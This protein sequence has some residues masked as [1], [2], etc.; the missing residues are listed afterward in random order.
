MKKWLL[1]IFT[2]ICFF[3]VDNDVHAFVNKTNAEIECIYANGVVIGMSYDKTAG[4]NTAYVKEY[5]VTKTSIIDGNPVSN[6]SLYSVDA[7]VSSLNNLSCPATVSYWIGW[8]LHLNETYDAWGNVIDEDVSKSYRGVYSYS[9][10][11]KVTASLTKIETSGWWIFKSTSATA[12]VIPVTGTNIGATSP[13]ATIPL[14]GERI[15]LIDDIGSDGYGHTYKLYTEN[16]QAVGS[17]KYV[18]IYKGTNNY[19]QVGKVITKLQGA[20]ANAEYLCIEPSV[21]TQDSDRGETAYK[22]SSIRHKVH[23]S[24][25]KT[26]SSG[27]LY[28]RTTES[29]KTIIPENKESFC[30]RYS[31]TAFVLIDI[32]KIMQILVPAIVIIFTGIEIGRIVLAGN[33]EEELP[34]RKKSIFIRGRFYIGCKLSI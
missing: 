3:I 24:T 34:K 26:C 23:A 28:V 12:G 15:Y 13:Y 18:Q 6:V 5:P 8:E 17:S 10:H 4:K 31:N 1:V 27:Q 29:C 7:T 20:N 33:I 19:I 30:D 16:E 9:N 14:V 11:A 32:I 21:T 2:I 22:F 25:S